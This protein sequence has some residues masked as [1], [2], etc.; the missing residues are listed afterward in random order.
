MEEFI[1]KAKKILIAIPIYAD[2]D[3]FCAGVA[4]AHIFNMQ[5]KQVSLVIPDNAQVKK[6]L[7]LFPTQDIKVITKTD[8]D[9]YI[10]SLSKEQAVIKDVKWKEEQGKI[11]IFI[12]TEK[13]ALSKNAVTIR[14]NYS[15]FDAIIT[16][17]V[18]SLK[19]IGEFYD[20]NQ[21]AFPRNKILQIGNLNRKVGLYQFEEDGFIYS[22]L[23]YK[24]CRSIGYEIDG[25]LLTNLLAGV[26]WKTDGLNRV[27]DSGVVSTIAE[28]VESGANLKNASIKAFKNISLRDTRLLADLMKNIEISD[29]GILF[30]IIKG[31]N[32]KALNSQELINSSWALLDRVEDA[33]IC[34][35]FIEETNSNFVVISTRSHNAMKISRAFSPVGDKFLAFFRTKETIE[36]VR[37]ELHIPQLGKKSKLSIGLQNEDNEPEPHKNYESENDKRNIEDGKIKTTKGKDMDQNINLQTADPLQPASQLPTPLQIG[38]NAQAPVQPQTQ[39]MKPGGFTPPPPM[40][41]LPTAD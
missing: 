3:R 11:N 2:Y 17:G 1:K 38:D 35:L 23:A 40:N 29:N 19:E 28:L 32:K 20:K 21:R 24:L 34:V 10:V 39:A 4:L 14:P 30:S 36:K 37:E 26:L 41:P 33:E 15:L 27:D 8:P 25:E 5:S 6:L 22:E 18:S 12:T 13:G 9:S 31:A 16:V 7:Q